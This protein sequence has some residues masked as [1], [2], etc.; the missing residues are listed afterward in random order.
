[1]TKVDYAALAAQLLN[2]IGGEEN[3]QGLDRG[4]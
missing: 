1:M 3:I 2:N 4:C